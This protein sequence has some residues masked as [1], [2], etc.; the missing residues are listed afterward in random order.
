MTIQ[1]HGFVELGIGCRLLKL[2]KLNTELYE[3]KDRG[4]FGV[5]KPNEKFPELLEILKK[6]LGF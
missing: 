5:D 1:T 4:H 2:L 3:F 6:K